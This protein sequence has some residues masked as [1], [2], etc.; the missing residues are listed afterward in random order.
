MTWQVYIVLCSDGSFYTGI[1]TDVTRRIA[2]HASGRGAKYVRGRSP[3]R[4]VYLENGH[5]RSSAPRRE[6][7]IK[8]LS[9][10][11]KQSLI[12]SA[13]NEVSIQ[14]G[15]TALMRMGRDECRS[16]SMPTPARG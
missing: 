9:R 10:L 7:V 13:T 4:L 3:L 14:E 11:G 6:A 1:T 8:G 15:E 5:T 16:G 12:F 2:Q